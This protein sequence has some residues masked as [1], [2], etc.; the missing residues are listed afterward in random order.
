MEEESNEMQEKSERPSSDS[1]E[2]PPIVKVSQC[3]TAV[4]NCIYSL[5]CK[6]WDFIHRYIFTIQAELLSW[7]QN[8]K[9]HKSNGALICVD[10]DDCG[11]QFGVPPFY[12]GTEL[13]YHQ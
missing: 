12:P 7:Q 8:Q 2:G 9:P 1:G 13:Y 11:D 3:E 10:C 5:S 6:N 4:P